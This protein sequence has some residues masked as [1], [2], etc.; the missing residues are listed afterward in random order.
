SDRI[1]RTLVAK[2]SALYV[3][4]DFTSIGGQ[5]RSHVAALD[6]SGKATS[7]N[8]DANDDVDA[9]AVKG[10]TVYA[11]GQFTSIGGRPRNRIAALDTSG[12]ATSFD[13][14]PDN[15]VNPRI[16]S[17]AVKGS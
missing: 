14:D 5:A 1:V 13:P 7:W 11:G 10:P 15:Y 4:G 9:L 3:G 12:K 2:R 17:I 6:T 8:P 16:E